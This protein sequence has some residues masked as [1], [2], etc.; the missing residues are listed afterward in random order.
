MGHVVQRFG[1]RL[2]RGWAVVLLA[3]GAVVG[4]MFWIGPLRPVPAE[5]QVLAYGGDGAPEPV[6][7]L[8]MRDTATGRLRFAVPLSVRNVGARSGRPEQLM[9]SVP[10]YYRLATRD[11]LLSGDVSPGV[12]LRRYAINLELAAIP[13]D[14]VVRALP[15]VDTI[16]VEPDLPSYYCTASSGPI[17]D[18]VPAP[19]RNPEIISDL[20]IFYSLRTQRADER[21]AGLLSVR[22]D[23]EALKVTPAPMPPVFPTTFRSPAVQEPELIGARPVG[24]RTA[25][26]GDPEQP[27]ELRTVLLETAT[28]GRVFVVHVNGAPRKRLYDLNRDSII[29]LETWDVDGDGYFDARREA[30]FRVPDFLVPPP[31]RIPYALLPDTVPPD[32][33][34]LAMFHDARRG[35]HRFTQPLP[36]PVAVVTETDTVAAEPDTAA[37]ATEELGPEFGGRPA[38]AVRRALVVAPSDTAG[39]GRPPRA[40]VALFNDTSAGPFRFTDPAAAAAATERA[41]ADSLEEARLRARRR[42]AQPLGTPIPYPRP[43]APRR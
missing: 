35:V 31:S 12:P 26:C 18:F 2:T 43:G 9:L 13:A 24:T 6:V 4:V 34:W 11:G 40:F 14:S 33:I 19:A 10:A 37:A 7:A 41:A 3:I 29:E 22:V 17:P 1:F 16:W 32:S 42:P 5:L 36:R 15:G 28:R 38:D 27:M 30:R 25:H 23:P 39:A 21:H 8:P 20:R